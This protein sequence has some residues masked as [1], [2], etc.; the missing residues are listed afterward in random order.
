MST[1]LHDGNSGQVDR[2]IPIYR[3]MEGENITVKCKFSYSGTKKFFCKGKCEK[4]NI[5]I[6]TTGNAAKNGR[7]SIQYVK[8]GV[9]SSDI[10]NVSIA[11][12]K[13]SDTGP[14]MCHLTKTWDGNLSHE[15]YILVTE[16]EFQQKYLFLCHCFT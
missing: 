11:Q 15:F 6:E 13:K 8:N 3:R 9:L 4:R 14:Y 7:Y 1:A 10:L 5:L 2:G 16:G 12:L